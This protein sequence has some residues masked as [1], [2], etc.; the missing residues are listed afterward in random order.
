ANGLALSPDGTRALYAADQELDERIEVYS[1]PIGGGQSVKLNG[2][3]VAGGDVTAGSPRF[4]FNG[5]RVL[6]HADQDADEVFE[7][8]SVASGGGIR[9]KLNGPMAL[10]GDV[11]SEGLQ[12]SSTGERILYS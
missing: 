11:R 9:V 6:Y 2:P 8:Y 1:V 3:L 10:N 12:F 4:N 5:S 7:I